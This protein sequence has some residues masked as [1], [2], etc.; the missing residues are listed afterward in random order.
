MNEVNNMYR[1]VLVLYIHCYAKLI[2]QTVGEVEL[3][4]PVQQTLRRNSDTVLSR[5]FSIDSEIQE[6]FED[7]KKLV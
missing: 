7:R 4:P 5:T 1:N 2:Q 6:K 3:F